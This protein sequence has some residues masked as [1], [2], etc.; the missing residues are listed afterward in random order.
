M[1]DENVEIVRGLFDQASQ[2]SADAEPELNVLDPASTAVLFEALDPG[3]E[4]HEDPRFPEAGIHRGVDAVRS[5]LE[6]FTESFA[7]FSFAAERYIDLGDGRVLVLL[8]LTT[9]GKGSGANVEVKPGWI[10][11]LRNDRVTRIDAFLDREQALEAA[12]LAE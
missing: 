1:S 4:F 7:E 3:I 11:T 5:Y 2:N 12:G 10:V 8:V 9:R 6:R